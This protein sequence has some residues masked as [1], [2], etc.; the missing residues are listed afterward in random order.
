MDSVRVGGWSVDSGASCHK[1]RPDQDFDGEKLTV[2]L[3]EEKCTML[4]EDGCKVALWEEERDLDRMDQ[5]RK[6]DLSSTAKLSTS[7]A[8]LVVCSA[9]GQPQEEE[10]LVAVDAQPDKVATVARD[11][12]AEVR[13]DA[14][15]ELPSNSSWKE[16]ASMRLELKRTSHDL[17]ENKIEVGDRMFVMSLLVGLPDKD[18]ER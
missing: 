2:I 12:A 6:V 8:K 3:S 11:G 5:S 4:E 16:F 1:T 7:T 9:A 17:A 10:E 13:G 18:V 14:G 15:L